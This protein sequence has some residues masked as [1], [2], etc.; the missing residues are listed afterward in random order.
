MVG[1][2]RL[3]RLV[4]DELAVG[5]HVAAVGDGERDLDVLLHQQH[6]AAAFLG[7]RGDD[8]EEALDDDRG[9]PER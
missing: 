4:D 6:G 5:E 1:A 2:Q 8:R 3:G 9:E 7:V